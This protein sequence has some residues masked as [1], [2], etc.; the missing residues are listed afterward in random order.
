MRVF[1]KGLNW[2][3]WRVGEFLPKRRKTRGVCVV[4]NDLIGDFILFTPALRSLREK[5]CGLHLTIIVKVQVAE[6][7]RACPYVDEVMI[8]DDRKFRR[9][10]LYRMRFLIRIYAKSFG[11]LLYTCYSRNTVGDMISLWAAAP[12][13]IGWDTNCHH[14][15]LAENVRGNKF[16]TQ[17]VEGT[18]GSN[19]HETVRNAAFL[20]AIGFRGDVVSVKT[21]VWPDKNAEASASHMLMTHGLQNK[22]LIAMLPGASFPLKNWGKSNYLEL[23]HALL[24]RGLAG[25]VVVVCGQDG[26][27]FDLSC[28]DPDIANKVV[29]LTGKTGLTELAVLLGNSVLVVGNDTGTMHLAIAMRARTVCVVGGGHFGRFVPYGIPDRNIFMTHQLPCYNC[30]WNCI[31]DHAVCISNISVKDVVEVCRKLLQ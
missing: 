12:V 20:E 23:T 28:L 6:L 17:L 11:T 25:L 27:G 9:Q 24:T 3:L 10:P 13:S 26:D 29:D 31:Y 7:L 2:L 22:K 30:N 15:S 4:R 1:N 14:M 19:V 8:L 16:Y 5:Y 21:E 18:F